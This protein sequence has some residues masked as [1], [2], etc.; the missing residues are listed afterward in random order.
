MFDIAGTGH[1]I[2]IAWTAPG[3]G[4][5]F[6]ALDR[7]GDGRIDNGKELF[8]NFTKQ[9]KSSDP[10]GFLALAEFDRP[11]NGGNGDGII[12][13]RDA[14]YP[15]LLLWIDGNHNGISE[16]N[17]LHTLP[18]LG[19]YS[20]SL[21]YRDD[22]SFFDQYGNWFHYQ[23]PLNPDPKDGESKDGRLAYDV[24]FVSVDERGRRV[25]RR[26]NIDVDTLP[27]LDAVWTA[28][29][30]LPKSSPE[31]GLATGPQAGDVVASSNS[32]G[33]PPP[34]VGRYRSEL[35][36][37]QGLVPRVQI[38]NDS[39]RAI[40]SLAITA[41]SNNGFFKIE[42]RKFYDVY[43]NAGRDVPISPLES[44]ALPIGFFPGSG[45]TKV[46]PKVRAVLFEDGSTV[47]EDVWIKALIA[48]RNH[49]YA[50]LVALHGLLA[51]EAGMAI[52]STD[53]T[54]KI[55]AAK[56]AMRE[57][58][59]QDEF[60]NVDDLVYDSAIRAFGY[61]KEADSTPR[62]RAY[63]KGLETRIKSLAVSKP[64]HEVTATPPEVP[65]FFEGRVVTTPISLTAQPLTSTTY[66]CT[67]GSGGGS[68]VYPASCTGGSSGVWTVDWAEN[69]AVTIY[70]KNNTTGKTS[71]TAYNAGAWD[72]EGLCEQYDTCSG[73]YVNTSVDAGSDFVQAPAGS[74]GTEFY[75]TLSRYSYS[76]S[77]CPCEAPYPDGLTVSYSPLVAYTDYYYVTA[78]N[79]VCVVTV[80]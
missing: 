18:S 3:S 57:I 28:P 12:D 76:T 33:A 19:V 77:P 34:Q 71:T 58:V 30:G 52:S 67:V 37:D 74:A 65:P 39:D 45:P 62:L 10:N 61:M 25:G 44:K 78:G 51:Q 43:V 5:A 26:P 7:D 36:V 9:P 20:I 63:M 22:R 24:F 13:E 2:Q 14:V 8:G 15:H 73:T 59:P 23:A 79:A 6:L 47:G 72:V 21:H 16:P 64:R 4:N 69:F 11:E 48:R 42:D 40:T 32:V 80:N 75:W 46:A 31:S 60:R 27:G 68:S 41:E 70:L 53:L 49:F 55:K 29:P 66:S 17:E 54:E 56:A 35:I 38:W 1:P 50:S